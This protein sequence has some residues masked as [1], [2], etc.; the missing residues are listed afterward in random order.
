MS[1]IDIILKIEIG[2]KMIETSRFILRKVEKADSS[3]IFNILNDDNVIKT[4]NMKRPRSLEDVSALL[5]E[6]ESSQKQAFAIIEKQTNTFL[7]VFL[8]KLD[9]YSEDAYEFTIYISPKFWGQGIYTEVL[10]YMIYETFENIGVKNFRGYVMENNT[11]SAKVLEKSNFILEKVFKVDGIDG[12]IKSYLMTY[13]MYKEGGT[14]GY[15][16]K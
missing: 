8:L 9:L 6:Y 10:P 15:T 12:N 3:E 16:E 4:L 2:D 7:G 5:K 13:D 14:Y 11:A 1:K